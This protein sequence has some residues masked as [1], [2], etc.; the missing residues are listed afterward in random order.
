MKIESVLYQIALRHQRRGCTKPPGILSRNIFQKIGYCIDF[1]YYARYKKK[2]NGEIYVH[3]TNGPIPIH[4]DDSIDN[5]IT[6]GRLI[7]SEGGFYEPVELEPG[8]EEKTEPEF[9]GLAFHLFPE[10]KKNEGAFI[11]SMFDALSEKK[12]KKSWR[13]TSCMCTF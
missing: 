10:L 1:G 6:D 12:M 8:F 13:H 4:F 7:F 9:Y 3:L 11:N 5:L 2:L